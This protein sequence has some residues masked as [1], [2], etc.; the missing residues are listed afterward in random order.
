MF[1]EEYYVL[2]IL[3]TKEAMEITEPETARMLTKHNVGCAIIESN[4]G[5]RGFA[6]NVER[7]LKQDFKTNKT[8]VQ[9]FTQTKNKVS[10]ILSNSTW[11]MEHIYFPAGWQNRWSDLAEHLTKYQRQGKNTHD[12]AEDAL[13]GVCEDITEGF[14]DWSG[15]T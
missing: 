15:Y 1:N 10:R 3:F 7:I 12:D 9:W 5:G 4:N 8:V 14:A 11:C 2:D 6:R 13:T